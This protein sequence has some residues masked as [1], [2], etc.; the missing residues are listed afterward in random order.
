MAT[1][2]AVY[3]TGKASSGG[4]WEAEINYTT[5]FNNDGNSTIQLDSFRIHKGSTT[6]S[7]STTGDKWNIY[8]NG[9][10]VELGNISYTV[11]AWGEWGGYAAIGKSYVVSAGNSISVNLDDPW[12]SF[13]AWGST[14]ATITS[15]ALPTYTIS[16][17]ANGG[18]GTV[19]PQTKTWGTP[20]FLRNGGFTRSGYNLLGWD[21]NSAA[22]IPTYVISD[23]AQGL[24]YTTEG[25][26]TLYAIWEEDIPFV[27][28]IWAKSGN[29][30]VTPVIK[31]KVNNT[32]VPCTKVEIVNDD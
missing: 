15:T 32:W 7:A 25:D 2:G 23:D 12:D 16:Y 22:T 20:L 17:N 24:R 31:I 30:W 4:N 27:N 18:S 14:A 11:P 28:M 19:S 1:V 13:Y 5:W 9:T 29:D 8:V 6:T 26:A 3:I 21:T 10:K